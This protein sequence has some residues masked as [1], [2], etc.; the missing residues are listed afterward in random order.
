MGVLRKL[1]SLS[2]ES[3]SISLRAFDLV[4]TTRKKKTIGAAMELLCFWEVAPTITG[5]TERVAR[6][7]QIGMRLMRFQRRRDRL[8][9]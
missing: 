2:V 4:F 8:N 9:L 3:P 7:Q 6:S 5:V 1:T